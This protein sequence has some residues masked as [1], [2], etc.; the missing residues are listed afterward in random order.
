MKHKTLNIFIFLSIILSN[1]DNFYNIKEKVFSLDTHHSTFKVFSDSLFYILSNTADENHFKKYGTVLVLNKDASINKIVQFSKINNYMLS[2]IKLIYKDKGFMFI[3]YSQQNNDEW[4]KIHVIRTDQNLNVLWENSYGAPS[5]E[6]K[7][8]SIV[9]E[10]D[11]EYWILGYTKTSKNGT[12]LLK[13]DGKGNEKWFTYL[14]NLNCN[15]ANN[16]IMNDKKEIIVSGQNK[17]QLF[18]AKIDTMGNVKWQYNYKDDTKYH[19]V[20]DIKNTNDR[21]IVIAGNTTQTK[22]NSFDVLIIKLSG[23]GEE[24]W[25]KTFGNKTNEVAYD[26]EQNE[27]LG[28]HIS[29]HALVDKK[30]KIYNS[31]IIEIDSIGNQIKRKDFI[32]SGSNKLYD[33][34]NKMEIGAGNIY[35]DDEKSKI[36]FIKL[37]DTSLYKDGTIKR[38]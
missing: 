25:I 12:L 34:N 36:W 24:K 2:G 11:D 1:P 5:S 15:F 18:V 27:K 3:G 20:Y 21:G 29:G 14:P 7:G 26:I 31:F 6:N 4:N 19:G 38:N 10:N 32:E 28:Y 33:I 22:D 30:N 23:K 37:D 8:Y 9:Q 16:M 13:I 35:D 17:N